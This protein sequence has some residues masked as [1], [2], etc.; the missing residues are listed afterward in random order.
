M[1]MLTNAAIQGYKEF[2]KRTVAYARYKI[3]STYYKTNIESVK[4]LDNGLVEV[5]FKIELKSGS[6]TVTEVQLYDTSGALWLTKVESLKLA[7]VSEGFYYS[8]QIDIEEV[9]AK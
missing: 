5:A 9:N 3:G 8:I 1:A 4:L 7:D 2:T 6:G